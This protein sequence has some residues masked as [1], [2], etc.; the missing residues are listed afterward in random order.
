MVILKKLKKLNIQTLH[1]LRL[2]NLV[3]AHLIMEKS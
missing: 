3:I 2:A 1:A